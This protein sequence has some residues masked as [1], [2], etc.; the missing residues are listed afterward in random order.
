MNMKKLIE[1]EPYVPDEPNF[2]YG[3]CYLKCKDGNDWYTSLSEFSAGTMKIAFNKDGIVCAA[4]EDASMLW[5][6]NMSVIEVSKIDVPDGFLPDGTW[7][8]DGTVI[9]RNKSVVN[10]REQQEKNITATIMITPLQDAVDS[11]IATPNEEAKLKEW[12]KYRA[13]VSRIDTSQDEI[14]WPVQP[15]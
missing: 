13:L 4:S 15:D 12:K 8:F 5:P 10:K 11:D 14:I 2:G 3:V 7:I 9:Y 6:V 1:L